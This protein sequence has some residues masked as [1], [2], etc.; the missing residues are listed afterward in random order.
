MGEDGPKSS[1]RFLN[2][3]RL[4]WLTGKVAF[5]GRPPAWP[6]QARKA[7]GVG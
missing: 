4:L 7:G 2:A 5:L 6:N 3:D 1:G